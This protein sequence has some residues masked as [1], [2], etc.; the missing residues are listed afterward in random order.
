MQCVSDTEKVEFVRSVFGDAYVGRDRNVSVKCPQCVRLDPSKE[1]STKKK[2][3]IR[4]D[5]DLCHCWVCGLSAK[6]LFPILKKYSTQE[7]LKTYREKFW[8]G[9]VC[10]DA[11]E[12]S[13]VVEL[14]KG[15]KL[16]TLAS[17]VDPDVRAVRRYVSTRGLTDVDVW[18]YRLGVSDDIVWR[19]RVVIPSFSRDGRVNYVVGRTIDE[20]RFKKYN[21]VDVP[22]TSV[23]FNEMNVRWD[24]TLVLCEGPFDVFKSGD[25]STCLLGSEL[26]ESHVLFDSIVANSTPVALC[27]DDDARDKS[28]RIAKKLREY[29]VDV[30]IVD[31]GEFHDPGS[32]TREQFK[33][34]L[35]SSKEWSWS[36]SFKRRVRESENF[37]SLCEDLGSRWV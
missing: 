31:V 16:L 23:I 7:R 32:M 9:R 37:S 26:N 14:P 11:V 21:N 22:K 8:D 30:K 5:D 19:R 13:S 24:K 4:L 15:F 2:F 20:K 33:Q 35:D 10:P 25:N 29:D 1:S 3:V 27:L 18:K 28:D 12:K 6:S 34:K 36:D 17:S